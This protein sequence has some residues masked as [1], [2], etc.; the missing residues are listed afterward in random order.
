MWRGFKYTDCNDINL[1]TIFTFPTFHLLLILAHISY[2]V[3]QQ[4]GI[5]SGAPAPVSVDDICEENI[6]L[7]T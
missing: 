5:S 2:A 1:E 7:F 6:K 3:V 4:E